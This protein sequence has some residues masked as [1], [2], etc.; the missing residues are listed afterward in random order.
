MPQGILL[1]TA[2]EL[3]EGAAR[4]FPIGPEAARRHVLVV[5]RQGRLH[6]YVNR[7]PHA[8]GRL[9]EFGEGLWD[10]SGTLLRCA[11]HGA[12][13]RPADGTCVAGPCP[14]RTLTPV[15][16]SEAGGQIRLLD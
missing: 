3:G 4:S 1:C 12:L 16:L 9:D 14:G 6:G 10:L 11:T 8:G 15:S 13:F 5:R 7:C 2:A